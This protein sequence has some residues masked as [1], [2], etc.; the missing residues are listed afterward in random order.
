MLR[1]P[2]SKYAVGRSSTLLK[3]KTFHDAEAVVLAHQPGKGRHKGRLGALVAVMDDGT[4]FSIGTGFT[5]TQRESPPPVDSVVTFRYQEL[6]DAGVPRFP[7]FVRVRKKTEAAA[8]PEA[9]AKSKPKTRA[10]SESA[11]ASKPQAKKES[12]PASAKTVAGKKKQSK[13]A[14]TPGKTGGGSSEPR[15]FEFNDGKSAK[16]WEIQIAGT[17]VTVRYGRIGS[18]GRIQTKSFS[19]K[20]TA[21]AHAEKLIEQKTGKGYV[22]L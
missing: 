20:A 12:A 6:T 11:A 8:K 1:E 10:K 4:E 22:E 3:V 18:D 9:E 14:Q 21:D 16:F 17:D 13:T 7:S 15:Y 2:R 5:D 19:D